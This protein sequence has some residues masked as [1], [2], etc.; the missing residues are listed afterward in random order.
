MLRLHQKM[1]YS[2][3]VLAKHASLLHELQLQDRADDEEARALAEAQQMSAFQE[4][5]TSW[6][7]AMTKGTPLPPPPPPPTSG[8][9]L[10]ARAVLQRRGCSAV[11]AGL[12]CLTPASRITK[13]RSRWSANLKASGPQY[14]LHSEC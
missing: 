7:L 2:S 4:D 10:Q 12:S 3:N 14:C 13:T 8:L 11:G 1:T 5:H 6:K 9:C